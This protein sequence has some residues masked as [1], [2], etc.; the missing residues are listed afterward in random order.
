MADFAA[1]SGLSKFNSASENFL[2]ARKRHYLQK[3]LVLLYKIYKDLINQLVCR[4]LLLYLY[5]NLKITKN[6]TRHLNNI[7]KLISD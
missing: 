3:P 7:L 4:Q 2:F 6:I 1:K 5:M